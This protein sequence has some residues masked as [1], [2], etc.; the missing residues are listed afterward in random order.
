MGELRQEMSQATHKA[1][2]YKGRNGPK[3]YDLYKHTKRED[4]LDRWM[5]F[6][7]LYHIWTYSQDCEKPEFV[8]TRLIPVSPGETIEVGGLYSVEGYESVTIGEEVS[9]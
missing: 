9:P 6:S 2:H 3:T 8:K 7:R 5:Y 1:V 4:G